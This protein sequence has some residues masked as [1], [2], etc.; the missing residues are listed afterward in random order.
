MTSLAYDTKRDRLLLHG[1]GAARKELWSF[2]IRTSRWSHLAPAGA[3]PEAS[4]EAVYLPRQ[5]V[6]LLCGARDLWEYSPA[7]NLWRRL[8]IPLASTGQNRAMVYD[9]KRDL[10]L[11][12]MGASEGS[13]AVFGLRYSGR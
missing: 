1:A 6:M 2:D 10:V 7:K 11:L 4:R 9:E 3:A 12:V 8:A 5:D 13:A